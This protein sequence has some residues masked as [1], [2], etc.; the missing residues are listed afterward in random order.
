MLA[1]GAPPPGL[2]IAIDPGHGGVDPGAQRAGLTEA[3]LML[4]IARELQTVLEASGHEVVLTRTGDDFVSLSGRLTIA[5]GFAADAFLSLH[6]DALAE[7]QA[8]GATVYTLSAEASDAASARMAERHEGSDLIGGVDLTGQGDEI[9]T[10]LL[11]LARVETGPRGLALADA[12][13]AALVAE[14]ARVNT[15]PRRS[16]ALA[17]LSAADFPSVLI[18]VGFLSSDADREVLASPERR[19]VI[20]NGIAVGFADWVRTD[21]EFRALLRQ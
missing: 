16:A 10:V 12:L 8:T 9:A 17:V 13:V 7:G 6:A 18:E 4:D 11:D 1:Q 5:R 20:L 19:A 21:A 2:R 3:D 15:A 14:G